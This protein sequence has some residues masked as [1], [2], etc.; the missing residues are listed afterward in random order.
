MPVDPFFAPYTIANS[1]CIYIALAI[2]RTEYWRTGRK[3]WRVVLCCVKRL[4]SNLATQRIFQSGTASGV[5]LNLHIACCS[6]QPVMSE[7]GQPDIRS[8]SIMKAIA[9]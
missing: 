5:S 4:P 8:P 9:P 3:R 7:T 2:F 6:Y 1:D